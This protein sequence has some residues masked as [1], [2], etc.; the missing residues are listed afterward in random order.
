MIFDSAAFYF[1]RKEATYDYFFHCLALLIIVFFT[2]GK[3]VENIF[4]PDKRLT[5]CVEHPDGIGYVPMKPWRA[6]IIQLLNIAGLG[7]I[8][9]APFPA[10][11]G[12]RVFIFGSYS[13]QFLLEP[14]MTICA[15]CYQSCRASCSADA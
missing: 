15:A 9:G 10:L 5:P 3:I 11:P 1:L 7:P 4:R 8:F 13:A 14:F 2:Y 12:N 6:F